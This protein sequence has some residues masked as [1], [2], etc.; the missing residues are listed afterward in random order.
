MYPNFCVSCLEFAVKMQESVSLIDAVIYLFLAYFHRGLKCKKKYSLTKVLVVNYE[1]NGLDAIEWRWAVSR[2]C[3][4]LH[5]FTERLKPV[6]SASF[7]TPAKCWRDQSPRSL[8]CGRFREKSCVCG[9]LLS[10]LNT[11]T[12]VWKYLY[13]S[14]LW[15][16]TTTRWFLNYLP[17]FHVSIQ[18]KYLSTGM[19]YTHPPSGQSRR[20]LTHAV[21]PQACCSHNVCS[22]CFS[23]IVLASDLLRTGMWHQKPLGWTSSFLWLIVR[24]I[25]IVSG[26]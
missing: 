19:I 1:W 18:L 6:G 22:A 24:D 11:H 25:F 16:Y 7:L 15:W 14:P 9:T 3:L 23:F 5:T 10:S 20:A 12:D 2:A 26:F 21:K 17:R 8:G 13:Y 4:A